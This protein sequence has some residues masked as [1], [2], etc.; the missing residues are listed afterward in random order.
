METF[1]TAISISCSAFMSLLNSQNPVRLFAS[2]VIVY[3]NLFSIINIYI[4]VTY[5]NHSFVNAHTSFSS[6]C[7]KKYSHKFVPRTNNV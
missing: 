6:L 4:K 7:R 3:K 5:I 2:T 1:N